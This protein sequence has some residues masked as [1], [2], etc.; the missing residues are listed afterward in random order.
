V[1]HAGALRSAELIRNGLEAEFDKVTIW[2]QGGPDG[3]GPDAPRAAA[4]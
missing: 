3:A 4:A 2:P 1:R